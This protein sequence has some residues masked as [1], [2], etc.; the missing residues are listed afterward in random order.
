MTI[1]RFDPFREFAALQDRM[2]RLFGDISLR[3]E[4]VSRRGT[5]VPAVDIY[6]TENHDLVIKAELPEM[7]REDIEV[8]VENSTLT[9]R[10]TRKLPA[11]VT[12]DRFRRI[13][14]SYG[15]FNRSFTLQNTVDAAK[16]SAEYKNGVLVVTLPF[17]EEAKPRTINVEVAA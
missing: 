7:T 4:D 8:T 9:L 14:R 10:G 11:D 16:V 12:E 13:E 1:V 5:W 3:D 15:D 6:E 2:N 17:R